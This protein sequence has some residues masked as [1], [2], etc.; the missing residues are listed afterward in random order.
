MGSIFLLFGGHSGSLGVA[1]VA[2]CA[3]GLKARISPD[4]IHHQTL[5][6]SHHALRRAGFHRWM[7]VLG[8]DNFLNLHTS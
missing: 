5:V 7:G 3:H 1:L 4:R 8:I 2:F 6:W